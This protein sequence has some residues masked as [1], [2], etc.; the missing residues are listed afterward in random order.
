MSNVEQLEVILIFKTFKPLK[1]FS[2]KFFSGQFR[3]VGWGGRHG[4][5]CVRVDII[6]SY[7]DN[8][9]YFYCTAQQTRLFTRHTGEII[10]LDS[11]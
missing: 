2:I 6:G 10:V 11:L 5:R 9:G 4:M 1:I 7:F 3:S 8:Q